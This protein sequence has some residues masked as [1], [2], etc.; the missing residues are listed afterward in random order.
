[1]NGRERTLRVLAEKWLGEE[2]ARA[3]RVTRFSHGAR[4]R[5]R[6]VCVEAGRPGGVFSIFFFRHDDGSW[7]VF[8]PSGQRPVMGGV[9]RSHEASA[10]YMGTN[11]MVAGAFV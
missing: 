10:E 7:C 2:G 4:R 3:A 9:Q 6:Y 1:M 8:P 5:W 11:E